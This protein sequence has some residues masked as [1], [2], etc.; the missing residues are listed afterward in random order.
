MNIILINHYAGSDKLGM[1]YRPYYFA[2]EW[3]KQGHKI[4]IIAASFSHI[5]SINPDIKSKYMWEEIEGIEYLWIRTPNYHSNSPKRFFNMLIFIFRLYRIIATL[6]LRMKYDVVIASSTYPLDIFPAKRIA[7]KS[8]AQLIFEVH[9][10]WPL[11]PMVLGGY[12]KWHPFIMLMQIAE[13]F[14]YLKSDKVISMLPKTKDHMIMHGLKEEKWFFIPNGINIGEWDNF[15][16]ISDNIKIILLSIREKY[17]RI[18]AYTGTYGL[19][20]SLDSYLDAAKILKDDPIAF[21]LFG[22]GPLKQHL[23]T[24]IKNELITNAFVFDSIP[25]R[26]IP[27]LLSFFDIL[28]IGWRDQYQLYKFGISPN[29]IMDYMMS[30][31]PIIHAVNAGNDM[32]ADGNCGISIEPENPSA[33]ALA[34]KTLCE[35]DNETLAEYGRNGRNYVLA[36]HVNSKLANKFIEVILK[37]LK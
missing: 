18:I 6:I 10:L 2:K 12:S 36:N 15:E 3:I 21:V 27:H 37:Q 32:V 17:K 30:A 14:A 23:E 24:R 28:Y 22:K 9:D 35:L 19:A 16:A 29:K 13:N 7:K 11:S 26:S 31:K 33:L 20:N 34:V 25:K 5:R 1:E 8:N 4:T